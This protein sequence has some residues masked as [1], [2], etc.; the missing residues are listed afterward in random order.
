MDT[1]SSLDI[2]QITKAALTNDIKSVSDKKPLLL[3]SLL[4]VKDDS[5]H[6][7]QW[8]VRRRLMSQFFARKAWLHCGQLVPGR[9]AGRSCWHM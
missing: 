9:R 2:I 4:L 3:L 7:D 5:L 6:I 1:L 8:G